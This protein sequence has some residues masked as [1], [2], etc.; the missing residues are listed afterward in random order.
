MSDYSSMSAGFL[1]IF[2]K[3]FLLW[4]ALIIMQT[5][6][7]ITTPISIA[8]ASALVI[9]AIYASIQTGDAMT[10]LYF[11]ILYYPLAVVLGLIKNVDKDPLSI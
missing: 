3:S 8:T 11:G 9:Y 7:F 5:R 6:K 10:Y 4:P 2:I 1:A